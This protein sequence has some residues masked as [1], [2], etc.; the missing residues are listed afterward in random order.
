MVASG[1]KEITEVYVVADS[2]MPV[3]PCG[4]CRQKIAEFA[5]ADVQVTLATVAG[6]E[7]V[8]TLGAL[9]PGAFGTAHLIKE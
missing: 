1:D 3:P 8:T 4:G 6:E 2:P 7:H 9:L 5:T